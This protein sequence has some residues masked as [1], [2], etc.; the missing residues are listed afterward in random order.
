MLPYLLLLACVYGITVFGRRYGSPMLGRFALFVTTV[1]LILFAG[2]R[3]VSVGTDTINYKRWFDASYDFSDIMRL[4]TDL[5][6]SVLIFLSKSISDSF[7]LF[8]ILASAIAVVPYVLAIFRMVARYEVGIYLFITLGAYTFVFNGLRQAIAMAITFWAVRFILNKKFAPYAASVAFA[9][10]FH[11][12]AVL[13]LP[14]YLFA[15]A[16]LRLSRLISILGGAVV[17]GALANSY[18]GS[19]V[20]LIDPR[21][22]IYT[23]S[24]EGG[25]AVMTVFLVG[26][27][28]IL[29]WL[30]RAIRYDKSKYNALLNIYLLSLVPALVSITASLNPSGVLRLHMYFSSMSIILWPM[31]LEQVD[32]KNRGFLASIFVL[33]TLLF[34]IATTTSYS[35]LTPYMMNMESN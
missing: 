10:F 12:T 21:F 3:D 4:E 22:A 13:A 6:F 15:S 31:I 24:A 11:L 26:Q 8:L 7:S 34:F 2:L 9:S 1:A 30:R 33:I 20:Q 16:K 29:T 32:K 17:L 19:V 35:D 27:A 14:L 5:L 23:T 18:L 25:G 28:V